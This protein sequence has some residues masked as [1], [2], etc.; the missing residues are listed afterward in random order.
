[1]DYVNKPLSWHDVPRNVR[2]ELQRMALG[3]K[4]G[5]PRFM[6]CTTMAGW[7]VLDRETGEYFRKVAVEMDA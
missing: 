2:T 6:E 7:F 3:Y 1:M 4:D 5:G